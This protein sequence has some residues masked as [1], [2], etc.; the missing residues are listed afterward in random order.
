MTFQFVYG[1][2][3]KIVNL[4]HV[5]QIRAEWFENGWS[6]IARISEREWTVLAGPYSSKEDAELKVEW[7]ATHLGAVELS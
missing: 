2:D 6:I 1:A 3:G 4:V 5:Q 7:I